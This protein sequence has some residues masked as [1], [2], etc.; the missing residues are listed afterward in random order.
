MQFHH[1]RTAAGLVE[2]L[3]ALWSD[4]RDDPFAFDLAVVP[5]A[6]FQR[7]LSQQLALAGGGAGVCAGVEFLSQ[8]GLERRLAG[9]DDP[10]RPDRLAWRVQQLAPGSTDPELE[11]LRRHLAASRETFTASRRIARQ[12]AGYARHRPAMLAAGDAGDD[13]GP[14]GSPLGEDAWQAHLYRLLAADLGEGPLLG[15]ENQLRRLRERPV[16]GC[17]RGSRC[18]RGSGSTRPASMSWRRSGPTTG[19]TCCCSPPHRAARHCPPPQGACDAPSSHRRR[20]T[21]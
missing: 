11:V 9:A 18:R 19:S 17:R 1:S 5:G 3:V 6:G 2:R 20:G 8:A 13:T 7:W 10:W 15:H 14:D 4:P 12:L 21:P 16:A